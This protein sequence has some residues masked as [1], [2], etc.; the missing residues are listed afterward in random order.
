[1]ATPTK[2]CNN[3]RAHPAAGTMQGLGAKLSPEASLQ[4]AP[5]VDLRQKI[6]DDHNPRRIIEARRRDRPDI[7]HDTDDSD[8]F[9]AFNS[10]II[11]GSCSKDFKPIAIPKYDG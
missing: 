8:R 2:R 3:L 1:V 11:D 9:P 4:N 10:N 5:T 6:N 7:Y